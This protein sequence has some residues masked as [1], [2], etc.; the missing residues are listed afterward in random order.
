M[1]TASSWAPELSSQPPRTMALVR[2]PR[3]VRNAVAS[4]TIRS[5]YEAGSQARRT[6]S[7]YAPELSPNDA[8][9]GDL[10]TIRSRSREAARNDG[11]A[12]EAVETWVS[13]LIGT[14]IKPLPK[15]ADKAFVSALLAVFLRWTD[16]CD[17]NGQLDFFGLQTQAARGWKTGGEMFVRLRPRLL[18]DGLSVPLQLEVI[19]PELCPHNYNVRLTNG[20][21]V[22]AGIEFD[23]IGRIVAYWFYSSRR[24]ELQDIDTSQMRRL[25]SDQVLHIFDPLRAGQLRGVPDIAQALLWLLN[26]KKLTDATLMRQL[27]GNLFAAFIKNSAETDEEDIDPIT[28]LPVDDD[29]GEDAPS[30][31]MEPATVQKLDPGEE[32]TFSTPP[33][34]HQNYNE[35]VRSAL[36]GAMTAA[37]IPYELAT[38][39]MTGVNDRVIRVL[40]NKFRRRLRQQQHQ[41]IAF[42]FNRR[43]WRAFMDAAVHSGAL[44]L[45]A[46]VYQADPQS[47][48]AVKWIPEGWPY[49]HPLQDVQ[50]AEKR[51]AAG[52]TSRSAEVSELGEDAEVI[53]AEQQADNAR[54]DKAG[55]KYTSDGR[56]QKKSAAPAPQNTDPDEDADDDQPSSERA[57]SGAT[58]EGAQV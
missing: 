33:T 15:A 53:D 47:W 43:V 14:G 8:V 12:K 40:L 57:S 28:G 45:D 32:V 16:E 4:T 26:V 51:I 29:E 1:A 34:I 54:A 35:F 25:T 9:L 44:P 11:Y 2:Q 3:E 56:N 58:S 6:R 27:V 46:R 31:A 24:G 50:A 30:V 42:Q 37:G 21:R 19:E 20:N 10:N 55:L 49:I 18:S 7:W 17:A 38:G 22:R 13:E 39:D 23:G 48:L 5:P 41:I 52:L 36:R